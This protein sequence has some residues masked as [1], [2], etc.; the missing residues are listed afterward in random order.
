MTR[1]RIVLCSPMPQQTWA[2]AVELGWKGVC[3]HAVGSEGHDLEAQVF[4]CE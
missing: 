2:W 1:G 4:R 3:R